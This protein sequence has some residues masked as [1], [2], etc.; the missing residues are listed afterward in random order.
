MYC[1]FSDFETNPFFFDPFLYMYLQTRGKMD[2]M[3]EYTCYMLRII[4]VSK[5]IIVYELEVSMKSRGESLE[6]R[7]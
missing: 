7:K 3:N 1:I 5:F 6:R 2:V 4:Q